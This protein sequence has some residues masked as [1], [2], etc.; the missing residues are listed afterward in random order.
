MRYVHEVFVAL[1]MS[2]SEKVSLEDI[3]T[4]FQVQDPRLASKVDFSVG[5]VTRRRKGSTHSA[6]KLFPQTI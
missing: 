1:P 6:V 5:G 2:S 4:L 3:Q